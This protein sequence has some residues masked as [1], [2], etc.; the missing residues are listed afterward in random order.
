[1]AG[2]TVQ[3]FVSAAVGMSV[4]VALS[5]GPVRRRSG[6]LGNIWVDLVRGTVAESAPACP[7]AAHR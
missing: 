7:P 4:A 2:L 5:R 3:N 6:T 1:M